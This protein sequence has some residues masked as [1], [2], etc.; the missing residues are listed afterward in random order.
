MIPGFRVVPV[1]G[2]GAGKNQ[3]MIFR[4]RSTPTAHAAAAASNPGD[5]VFAG[6][7]AAGTPA[8]VI[9]GRIVPAAV[10]LDNPVENSFIVPAVIE[11]GVERS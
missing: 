3:G 6:T 1:H 10:S 5:W 9:S 4:R 11:T 7:A 2:T 8:A